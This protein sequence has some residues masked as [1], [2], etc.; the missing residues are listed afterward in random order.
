MRNLKV[1]I[2]SL[3]SI[4]TFVSCDTSADLLASESVRESKI[5]C[6][7]FDQHGFHGVLSVNSTQNDLS[8]ESNTSTL[9]FYDVP[10]KFKT[11]RDSYIQLYAVNYVDNKSSFGEAALE[12]DVLNLRNN[13][14]SSITPYIDHSFIQNENY[15]LNDFFADHAF[16]IKS[17]GG[18]DALFIGLF[19]E[20]DQA[21]LKIKILV[22]PLEAN[23]YIYA[24]DNVNNQTLIE[25][26]PFNSLK[27]SI[28]RANDDVFLSKAQSACHEN[29]I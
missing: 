6:N 24:E 21:I 10:D 5:F 18:W 7:P 16:I 14:Y 25:L 3:V 13:N 27:K 15:E 2:F 29:P 19:N 23:P 17:T 8:Y 26:H 9:T 22:P 11:Q 20:H 1:F 28:D 12:M 4:W